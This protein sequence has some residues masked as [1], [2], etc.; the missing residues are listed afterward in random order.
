MY[1]AL[2]DTHGTADALVLVAM[3]EAMSGDHDAARAVFERSIALAT[4]I[5]DDVVLA[6]AYQWYANMELRFGEPDRA[7][8][9][10]IAVRC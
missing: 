4:E 8:E 5:G 10:S 7:R 2:G 9:L 6:A 1:E 3:H